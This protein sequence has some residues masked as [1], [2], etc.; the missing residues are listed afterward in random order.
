MSNQ[1]NAVDFILNQG[2]QFD[3]NTVPGFEERDRKGEF[4][5]LSNGQIREKLLKEAEMEDYNREEAESMAEED[6]RNEARD[7]H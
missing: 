3:P 6:R 5:K 7:D 4:D 2:D 1:S